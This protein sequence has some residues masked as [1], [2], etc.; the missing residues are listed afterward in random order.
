MAKFHAACLIF[1][2]R[3][4]TEPC[5]ILF[6]SKCARVLLGLS[7]VITSSDGEHEALSRHYNTPTMHGPLRQTSKNYNKNDYSAVVS[8]AGRVHDTDRLCSQNQEVGLQ[9]YSL[10][11][12]KGRH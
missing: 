3:L 7:D 5:V 8:P 11:G 10:M 9:K 1:S 6:T 12:K 2:K 4:Q